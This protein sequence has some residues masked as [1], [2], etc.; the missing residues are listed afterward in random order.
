MILKFLKGIIYFSFLNLF[1]A[2]ISYSEIL[3]DIKVQGNERISD[4]TIKM[5]SNVSIN[6]DFD[7]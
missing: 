4:E 1:V 5:F 6:D 7:N 2:S 3:R